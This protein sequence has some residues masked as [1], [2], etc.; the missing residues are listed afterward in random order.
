MIEGREAPEHV[1]I[2]GLGPSLEA[3]IDTTKRL[4]GRRAF[5]DETWGINAVGDIVQ[6]DLVFHMDD[7]RVQEARAAA[8]PQSNIANMLEWMKSYDGPIMTSVP[9]HDYPGTVA[10]PLDDVVNNVGIVY[11]NSTAAYAVAYAVA[12]GVKKISTFGFDFTY[13][14]AHKAER[15]RACVEF[16]LGMAKARGIALGTC[17]QSTILD[18][19]EDSDSRTYGYDGVRI[20]WYEEAGVLRS[21]FRDRDIPTAE[22]IEARYNHEQHPNT[23]VRDAK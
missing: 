1:T 21:E 17:G 9:H 16:Y 8:K 13:P 3:Y 4:G 12:I 6:C 19:V 23:L 14:N 20:E 18:S 7:I 10:Y 11:F 5:S 2:L 22:E 15:G